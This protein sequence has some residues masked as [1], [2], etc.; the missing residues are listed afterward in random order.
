MSCSSRTIRRIAVLAGHDWQQ[1]I[2]A[3]VNIFVHPEIKAFGK[4]QEEA[5]RQWLMV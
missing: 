3:I 5:A 2:A 1:W 4:K